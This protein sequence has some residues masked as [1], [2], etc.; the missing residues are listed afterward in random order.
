[1][2]ATADAD[3]ECST[4]APSTYDD[5]CSSTSSSVCGEPACKQMLWQCGDL[6]QLIVELGSTNKL[7]LKV[8]G[9]EVKGCYIDLPTFRQWCWYVAFFRG[10]EVVSVVFAPGSYSVYSGD[11]MLKR[12]LA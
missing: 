8:N 1:M 11:H 2:C 5:A 12:Y 4:E 10:T 7:L 3:D 9:L 6:V